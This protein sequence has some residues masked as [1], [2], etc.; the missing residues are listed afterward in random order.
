MRRCS[1]SDLIKQGRLDLI[2]VELCH[3]RWGR[4]WQDLRLG[5][6]LQGHRLESSR[7]SRQLLVASTWYCRSK[8]ALYG[9]TV[10]R[11]ELL[12]CEGLAALRSETSLIP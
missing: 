2:L 6:S 4:H 1:G 11:C 9:A 5:V 8:C 3:N 10:V 7:Y 12:P